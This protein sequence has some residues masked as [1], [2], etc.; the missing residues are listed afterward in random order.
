MTKLKILRGGRGDYPELS[1]WALKCHHE[2]PYKGGGG[3]SDTGGGEGDVQ[4]EERVVKMLA[5]KPE[6]ILPQAKEW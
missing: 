2:C 1:Q 3:S 4:T 6:E 5:L